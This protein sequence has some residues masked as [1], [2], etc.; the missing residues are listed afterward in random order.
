M[1]EAEGRRTFTGTGVG[2]GVVA[3]PV[4]R[5]PEPL[6][7]PSA[8]PFRGDVAQEQARA[9][10]ALIDTRADLEARARRAGGHAQ[11]VLEAQAVMADDPALAEEV[12]ARIAAGRTA[13]RA[14]FEAL[15]T[16]Q[17]VLFNLGEPMAARA[18]DVGDVSQ[19]VIARLLGR[20]VPGPPDSDEPFVLV[21]ADLAPA[22][23]ALLDLDLV[24]ALVTSGGSATSHT[25]ILARE[26]SLIAVVGVAGAEQ[27][28][29]G[30]IV[31][32]D[33]GAG[34][35]TGSPTTRE[36]RSARSTAAARVRVSPRSPGELADGTPVPLL[37]NLGSV[38]AAAG[39]LALGAEGVGLFRTE[40][41][42][43]DRSEAPG[44]AEQAQRYGE[45]LAAFPGRRVIVRVFDAGADKPLAFLGPDGV[46]PNPALGVRG[47]R[48]LRAREGV[49]RDQLTALALAQDASD[50]E[51]WVMAPMVADLPEAA[52]FVTLA[53]RLGLRTVG[54]MI[55]VPSSALLAAQILGVADFVSIGTNDLTQYT[56][57]ADRLSAPLGSYQDPWHPAVLRLVKLVGDAGLAS[58]R[59][60]GV[61]GEAAAD[62]LLAV[63]LVGLGA[64]SLSVAPAALGEVRTELR[65][66]TLEAARAMA[67]DA[68]SAASPAEARAAALA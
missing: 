13:E 25:A 63:V 11:D 14:V 59:S 7:E 34:V 60:I 64:T 21:A 44:V 22:D 9:A 24:L 50:A 52:A 15:A 46:E 55:E 38:D 40:L 51:L 37:A 3:G 12:A 28:E 31:L 43:L 6:A 62:P 39:A 30:E 2:R 23:A 26:Q 33:A 32:V 67:V 68:L 27:F 41:L 65:R 8:D 53:K 35:V 4:L 54:V 56:L 42:F 58:G 18:T 49:L 5:M 29:D 16:V 10:R 45:L 19:R 48:A 66:Y 57:A 61:C 17:Q 47:L 20:P 36:V 1:R